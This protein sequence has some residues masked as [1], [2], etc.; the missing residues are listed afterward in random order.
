MTTRRHILAALGAACLAP[1]PSP[2]RTVPVM[3]SPLISPLN[4]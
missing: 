1:A 3:D 2:M 4:S